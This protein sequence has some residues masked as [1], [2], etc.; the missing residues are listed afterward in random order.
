LG[1]LSSFSNYGAL[2]VDIGAPGSGIY[3]CVPPKGKA[4]SGYASYSG[5]SMAAPHVT[6]AA[7]LYLSTHS[8]A[9]VTQIINAIKGAATST[10]SL[11]GKCVTGGRLNVGGF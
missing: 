1:K 10:T 11:N 8:G 9:S 7:A 6:G 2:S 4:S 5:T 3:S